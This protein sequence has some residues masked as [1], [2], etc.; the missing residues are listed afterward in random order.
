MARSR[1]L[2]ASFF[3]SEQV[4]SC[5]PLARLTF[6]GLWCLADRAGKLRDR[7]RQIRAELFP[8]QTE[9][10]ADPWLVELA[11]AGLIV[12][13]AVAG[14]RYIQIPKFAAH[15]N[16]HPREATSVLPDPEEEPGKGAA[17][18]SL[19]VVQPGVSTST[20]TSTSTVAYGGASPPSAVVAVLPCIGNG[21]HDYAVTQAEIDA[22][23][24]AYPDIDVKGEV[25][26]AKAWLE[27]NPDS[28]KP[29]SRAQKFLVSW[30]GRTQAKG[31]GKAPATA[32]AEVHTFTGEIAF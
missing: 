13:Y 23:I 31:K 30:F 19:G 12:R 10:D 17:R 4:A 6:A 14:E 7:P 25:L 32:A 8:Y 11:Q 21:S 27:A 16:V 3:T 29:Q 1:L 18:Q 22:W 20:S 26:R 2:K 24:P 15:Q 28:R 5:S 9:P